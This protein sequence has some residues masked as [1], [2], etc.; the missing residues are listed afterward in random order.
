LVRALGPDVIH[1]TMAYAQLVLGLALLRE[2]R[3][4]VWFQHGPVGGQLDLL[5]TLFPCD[6]LLFNSLYLRDLHHRAFP[7]S[8]FERE[9]VL[10]LGVPATP[11]HRELFTGETVVF[12]AAG[13]VTPFKAF[14]EIFEALAVLPGNFEF[15]LA[16]APKLDKDE[17]YLRRL[18]SLVADRGLAE[19]VRFLGHV[20]DMGAFYRGLDVFV[21][22][23][24]GPE[25]FGL[26][27]AE[28][29]GQGCLVVA[30]PE[31]GAREFVRPEVTALTYGTMTELAAQLA[32]I[33]ALRSALAGIA[34]RGQRHIRE[35][36]GT[37]GMRLQLEELY[38]L[39]L[40]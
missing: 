40:R 26:V 25:P 6:L 17:A 14:E 34:E 32:R 10:A 8:R 5:A 24:R 11:G 31:G 3:K 12:G 36:H 2:P 33:L 13:R 38:R 19:K 1:A 35:R 37:E 30:R 4:V 15:R 28:A 16:G 18:R 23:A 7:H 9:A 21:H 22:S 20:D 29:M 27:L 39:V